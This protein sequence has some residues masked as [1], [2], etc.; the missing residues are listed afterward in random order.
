MIG[1]TPRRYRLEWILLGMVLLTLGALIGNWLHA[2]RVQIET[3]EADRLQVQARVIDE[4]LGRQL[5]GVNEALAGI[6][7]DFPT[8]KSGNMGPE[9]SH[10][11][12]TLS[13]AMPGV[14]TLIIMDAAGTVLASSRDE[15]IGRNFEEREYFKVPRERPDST[16]LYVSPPFKTVLGVFAV[17]LTRAVIGPDGAFAGVVSATLDPDYFNV[18]L[19]S[20]LYAPDMRAV[21]VHWDGKPFVAMPPYDQLISVDLNKPGS[22]FTQHRESG[23]S[24]TLITDM[25]AVSG[26]KRMMAMRT[27]MGA[28]APMDKPLVIQVSRNLSKMYLPWREYSLAYA[29]F[30]GLIAA[31]TILGLYLLQRRRRTFDRLAA[32]H[33]NERRDGAER[34]ELALGGA[35]MGLWDWHVPSGKV[36]FDERWCTMLGYTLGEIEPRYSSWAGMVHP[37]DWPVI[38]AVLDPHLKGETKAYESEHR[39]RHKDGS[40]V[41]I[42]DRGKVMERDTAGAPLR[43]VG[44]HMNITERKRIE[45]ESRT[46]IQA[47]IDGFWIT[48]FSGRILDANGAICHMLGY[49]REELLRLAIRDID[50]EESP[51]D[52]AAR[53][54]DIIRTGS[55]LFQV[56]HRR[57]DGTVIDVEVNVLYVPSLGERFFAFIRDITERKLAE[58]E[59]K[60]SIAFRELLL[61]AMPL[62]IFY[63]DTSGRYAGGNS[64]FAAFLGKPIK[65]II[66]KTVF[67]VSPQS[68]AQTYRDKDLDL[69]DDPLGVQTYES[70][71]A[72][73]DGTPH[74]VIF[75]KARMVDNAGRPTGIL[76]VITDITE[77]KRIAAA[78]DRLEAQLRESQKMEALGT[79]AGGVAH[80]F[81]NIVATILGNV[82]LARQE[83]EPAHPAQESLEEILKASRRAKDLVQQ[84][85]AFGRRQA[86]E[87]QVI[88]LAPVAEE[89]ARLLRS[90]LPAG[91]RLSV[92]CAPDAPPVLADATQVQQVL[93]NLCANAWQAMQGQHGPA[94]IE[95]S[96]TLRIANG[97]PYKRPE[98]RSRGGRV[99]LRQGR[100]ACLTVS[101]TGP[102]MDQATRSRIFEP[103]FT[104][105]PVGKGT[106]LGLAVVHGIVQDHGASIAV[107]SAPGEGA[108]FRIFF[109]ESQVPALPAQRSQAE[110]EQH[111][112]RKGS[113]ESPVLRGEGKSILY[114]DD[115]EAIVFLMT[116]LMEREGYRVS[117]HTDPR[118]ALEAV[119][120]QPGAFDLVVT[121]YNM[122]GMSG[123]ELARALREIRAD[124]PVALAS[125]YITEEMR[126]QAPAAGVSE[127]IYKPNTVDELCE[128]VARLA[129]T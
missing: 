93:L 20:V 32:L 27:F 12:K 50:A 29:G 88:S 99:A 76:G 6:R 42:L 53:I 36:I 9:A 69:L 122:P 66:G 17:F 24:A 62:P 123:L 28:G 111:T 3:I 34:L 51:D 115:D 78:R 15:L 68:L 118:D 13:D 74:N 5:E 87:R 18:L 22:F 103:F 63:K 49:S 90:T 41:W 55:A 105:K 48:D 92:E 21:L 72:H 102:G 125:G 71:V 91:V 61:E 77:I 120:S 64:A 79:L 85:L 75:H 70:Q 116:R 14:R 1:R 109:P 59:L 101:D 35:D 98:R 84:I 31:G 107:H 38:H 96:L 16:V 129:H 44:T 65:E 43:V 2:E 30:Y 58:D 46:I 95:I 60:K 67:E 11:L 119:R 40:W 10:Q 8:W 81:N 4:N 39:M 7:N 52:V 106:G 86:L 54:G 47:S 126:A 112:A 26:E 89:S 97:A 80:D 113:V 124:L 82:E 23:Q 117:G 100:Y 121:D 108:T 94:A 57:K 73:V 83:V 19:R 25:S 56:R 33:E 104:T 37:D 127:L 114:V 45:D 110:A 128:V